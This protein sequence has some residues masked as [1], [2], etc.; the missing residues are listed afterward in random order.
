MATACEL[1]KVEKCQASD[2]ISYV[3]AMLGQS[4]KQAKHEYLYWEFNESRGPL[5]AL[6]NDNWKLVKRYKKPIELYDLSKDIGE[7]NNIA[8]NFPEIVDELSAKV[9][10]ARTYHPEFTLKK[11]VSPW[12]KQTKAER[13]A[14]DKGSK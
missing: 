14:K 3:P 10:S 13:K 2:G 1:A 12:K 8:A 11:L 6:R 9:D 4:Q 5:Q 7:S